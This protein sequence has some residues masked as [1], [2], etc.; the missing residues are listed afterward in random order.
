VGDEGRLERDD[1]CSP[2]E[3]TADFVA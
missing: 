1:R 3:G 2:I